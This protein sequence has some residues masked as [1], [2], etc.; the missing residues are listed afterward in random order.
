MYEA[1]LRSSV[2]FVIGLMIAAVLIVVLFKYAN[3]DGKVRTEYDERQKA[4]RGKAYKYAYYT[5]IFCQVIIMW[6]FMTG[7]ELPVENY[8][9]SFTGIILSCTVLAVYC[10]KNDVYWGLN[11]DHKRYHVIFVIALALNIIPPAMLYTSKGTL[12]ENG[13][14]GMPMLN[15]VVIFMMIVVYVELFIKRILSGKSEEEA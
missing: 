6:L 10:I 12:L 8:A 2:G 7:I 15:I 13:K 11:N 9:L 3:K 14:I 4:V 5:A 1:S